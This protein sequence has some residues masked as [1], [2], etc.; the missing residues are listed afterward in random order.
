MQIS[1]DKD[2]V[3][4][5]ILADQHTFKVGDTASFGCTGARACAGLVTF[6]GARVLEYKLVRLQNGANKLAIP[7]TARLAPNFNLAVA[8]MTEVRQGGRAKPGDDEG[9][10]E[11]SRNDFMKPPAHSR[12][13]AS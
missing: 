5:R 10:A 11:L 1:D 12:S 2:H 7:I 8:V 3:R 6:Q 9:E 4:L 13:N